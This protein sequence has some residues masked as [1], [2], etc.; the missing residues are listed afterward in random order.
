MPAC[1]VKV[2]LKVSIT[3]CFFDNVANSKYY[4]SGGQV[5]FISHLHLHRPSIQVF[6]V[7]RPFNFPQHT[8]G[9]PRRML[10]IDT[11]FSSVS[12]E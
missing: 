12:N 3:R 11:L 9:R 6:L 1:I 7:H 10:Q 2:V 8:S 5:S 4:A